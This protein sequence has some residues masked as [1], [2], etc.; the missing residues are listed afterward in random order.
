MRIGGLSLEREGLGN[1]TA[2]RYVLWKD[3]PM[4]VV[5]RRGPDILC[6]H[7]TYMHIFL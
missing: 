1:V 5:A 4:M 3:M 7:S 2:P 6:T